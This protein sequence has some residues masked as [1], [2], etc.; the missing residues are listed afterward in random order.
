MNRIRLALLG[1]LMFSITIPM[2][3]MATPPDSRGVQ[4]LPFT[5]F[6]AFAQSSGSNANEIVLT[7]PE[8]QTRV[9]WDELIASWNAELKPDAYLKLEVRAIYTNRTTKWFTLGLWSVDSAQHPRESVKK[10]K[11]AD[12]DV[13]T[14]TF[15]LRE[16]TGRVQVRLTLGSTSDKTPK[17]KFFSLSVLD[18]KWK[19]ESREPNRAAWGKLLDVT[20]R[21]QMA[22]PNGEVLCS[23][24]T[25]SMLLSYWSQKLNRPGLD[26]DVPEVIKGVYDSAW[27]GTGNW[28]FNTAFAGSFRWMRAYT[29]R[30]SNVTEL[31][32]FIARGIP[33]GL[34]VCYNRLRGKGREPSGHLVVLVGFTK[35]GDAI[36]NDPGTSK[37]VR[38]VFPRA[39][40]IDAWAYSKNAVYLVYPTS[41][42]LPRDEAGHWESLTAK[43][44][45]E[46][47]P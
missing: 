43:R 41:T 25:T 46:F 37:N 32:G 36:I 1:A 12:G 26:C 15:Q 47:S 9:C 2:K 35:D 42:I 39:N 7:S 21:S 23:A 40:L 14:D 11:D 24:T 33:V 17:L 31:E 5:S 20:E 4:F 45:V 6:A 29:T 38:K 34:S 3:S 10:Q 16:P 8:I 22:Y 19:S 13:D 44:L 28:V 30:L 18:S 27:G